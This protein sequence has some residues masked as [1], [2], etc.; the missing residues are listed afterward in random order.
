MIHGEGIST[1]PRARS[2]KELKSIQF[3]DDTFSSSPRASTYGRKSQVDDL[4]VSLN[5]A[6]FD[7][8]LRGDVLRRQGRRSRYDPRR[9]TTG[10]TEY[11]TRLNQ[12]SK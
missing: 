7:R 10:L 12:T 9:N 5:E 11:E 8:E 3:D 2:L 6:M 1:F 4:K